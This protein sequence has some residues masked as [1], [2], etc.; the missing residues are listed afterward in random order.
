VLEPWQ[1]G[2]VERGNRTPASI[3][4]E[5]H[6]HD[7]GYG[8][9]LWGYGYSILLQA[10]RLVCTVR[11]QDRQVKPAL[12]MFRPMFCKAIVTRPHMLMNDL[13]TRGETDIHLIIA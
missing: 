1:N 8:Y 6:D 3:A 10:R 2:A 13:D 12:N 4:R 11:A 5:F 9:K 7:D